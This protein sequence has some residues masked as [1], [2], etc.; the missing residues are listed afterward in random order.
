MGYSEDETVGYDFKFGEPPMM[1]EIVE[2]VG[3]DAITVVN[4]NGGKQSHSPFAFH[5]LDPDFLIEYFPT[6]IVINDIATYMKDGDK[7]HLKD[8]VFEI[9]RRK[10]YVLNGIFD[11]AKVL[12]EGADKY[13]TNNWR[14]IPAEQHLNHAITHYLADQAGDTQDSHLTHCMCRLMMAYATEESPGFDYTTPAS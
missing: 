10:E 1:K 2:G 9:S 14:L 5:L 12:K 11:I 8:A 13:Q 3:K 6:D 7:T 4:S